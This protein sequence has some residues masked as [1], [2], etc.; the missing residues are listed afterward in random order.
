MYIYLHL[1]KW[2]RWTFWCQNTLNFWM[3]PQ[4]DVY[5]G[6]LTVAN[7]KMVIEI[8]DLPIKNGDFS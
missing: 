6:N 1:P 5:S 8:V 7:L 4:N 2:S 3:V